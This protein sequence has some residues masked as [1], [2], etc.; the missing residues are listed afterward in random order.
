MT[1]QYNMT[2]TELKETMVE[3]TRTYTVRTVDTND[4]VG[5]FYSRITAERAALKYEQ[6]T[7]DATR[8]GFESIDKPQSL[9][10]H[11]LHDRASPTIDDWA[12]K[13]FTVFKVVAV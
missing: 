13:M 6:D 3:F 9:Y 7:D 1:N 8:I 11:D 12:F 4:L 5:V 2:E 10:L